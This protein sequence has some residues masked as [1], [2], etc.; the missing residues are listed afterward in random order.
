M[1]PIRH[2]LTAAALGLAMNAHAAPVAT[3]EPLGGALEAVGTASWSDGPLAVE[4]ARVARLAVPAAGAAA[5]ADS[6]VVPKAVPEPASIALLGIAGAA[7]VASRRRRA[8]R[9]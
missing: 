7:L 1:K 8:R 2:A 9:G 3:F 5:K 6:I 4:A